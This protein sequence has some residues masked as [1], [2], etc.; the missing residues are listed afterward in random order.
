MFIKWVIR[1]SIIALWQIALVLIIQQITNTLEI[2]WKE[3]FLLFIWLFVV[4]SLITFLFSFRSRDRVRVD[5][6]YDTIKII[7]SKR[8][9]KFFKLDNNELEKL[10]TGKLIAIID[11]WIKTRR[12]LLMLIVSIFT[13][14]L[15]IT[16]SSF[17][18]ICNYIGRYWAIAVLLFI[19][20]HIVV[21]II[22]K[23]FIFM[24]KERKEQHLIYQRFLVR[25]IMSKNEIIQANK[26]DYEI[27]N[28]NIQNDKEKKINIKMNKLAWH[29]Y[30]RPQITI[31]VIKISSI[32]FIW[33]QF[34]NWNVSFSKLIAIIAV[35][36]LMEK[37]IHRSI[38]FYKEMTDKF[39]DVQKMRDIFDKTAK[40]NYNKWEDFIYKKWQIEI[41][42]LNFCYKEWTDV[43]QNFS[44]TIQWWKKTAL[45]GS[46]GS[47]KS[48]LLKI[49]SWYIKP[50]SWDIIIDWQKL[51]S[52]KNSKEQT[53]SLKSYY[54][55]IGYL[56]QDPSVFDGTIYENLVYAL[57]QE[58]SKEELEKVIQLAK[59]EFIRDFE[60][61]LETEIW[62]KWIRLSGGQKQRLA[63]AK[64]MLKNPQIILLDEP[65]SALDSVSEQKISEALHNLFE[66]KTVIIIAH[67][68]QTIREVDDILVLNEW[69]NI[70]RWTHKEL[71][72]KKWT[73]YNML[74]LQTSF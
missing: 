66:N 6:S 3:N 4:I 29:I 23:K 49:I 5:I 33:L 56:T 28:L 36:G 24:R 44:T 54:K 32:F 8:I 48:T 41:K 57:E 73:Y 67:R 17:V 42:N 19:I 22:N 26:T 70:E 63:I 68:L 27:Q 74:K 50:D 38:D 60:K 62:E 59:C 14:T 45:I 52:W 53:V 12:E 55:H 71:E 31:T 47:W 10:W 20:I 58:L 13:D 34:I 35:F 1:A 64:I 39:I 46:S 2:G 65:T 7:Q 40:T 21:W 43:F 9:K 69:K 11:K 25:V 18:V 15:V 37:S 61:W 30:N 51:F 72:R 16:I